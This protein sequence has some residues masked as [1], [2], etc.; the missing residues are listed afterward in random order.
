[1]LR[2]TDRFGSLLSGNRR[3]VVRT[4]L[5]GIVA[6]IALVLAG[7]DALADPSSP[8]TVTKTASSNPVASGAQLT[9]TIVV[10]NTA[11]GSISNVVFND[12][13]NGLGVIQTPPA[14]PQLILTSTK[15]SCS[16]GGTNGNLVTCAV[17]TMAGGESFTVTIRGQVTAGAGTTLNNTASVTGTKSAQNF[18]TQSNAVAVLVTGGAGGQ[19]DL[20]I[21]K[22]G[23]TS[24]APS[25]AMTY[26]LTVNNIG[27]ANATNVKVVDTLPSGVGLALSNAITTTSLFT[28]LVTGSPL[29]AVTVTCAGGAVNAGQ[30]G[31]ITINATAPGVAGSI[32]NTAVVDPDNTIAETNEL[33]NTSASVNTAVGSSPPPTPLLTIQNTDGSPSIGASWTTG[34]GPDPVNPGQKL[35][36]KIQVINTAGGNNATAND[37]VVTDNTQGLDAASI[38][39]SQT[40]VG[41][42]LAKTDGCVV[43]APQV[44][45]T[46]KAMSSGGTQ[47]ITISGTVQQSAGSSLFSTATVTGNVKNTG[48]SNTASEVTTIRPQV[49]LTITKGGLP[50]PVCAHSWPQA[51]DRSTTPPDGIGFHAPDLLGAPSGAP[52][53][54]VDTPACLG[55]LR[56]DF[57]VGNS[58]NGPATN[59]VVRD[60]LPAGVTL[61]S[62]STDGSFA[63]SVDTL[64][65]IVT[66]SNGSIPAA[67]TRRISFL[68]V[69]PAYLGTI[70]NTATVDPNNAIFEAD[71][72]NNMASQSTTVA[73]GVD[74]VIWKGDQTTIDPPGGAPPLIEGFDPIATNG[75]ETYT[76]IVDNVGTQDSTG[77]KVRD[78]L[79]A[80]TKFLSVTSDHGFTCS[81]DGAATGGNV[82]CISG[83]LLGTES[84]FYV[85][86]AGLGAPGDD[87]ATITIKVFVTPFVQLVGQLMHNEVRVDPD[88][89]IPEVNELNNLATQDTTVGVGDAGM[90]AF[91]QLKI[92]KTQT[93][94]SLVAGDPNSTVATNG[95]LI[96]NL[97]VENAGTDP[98]SN[99][100]VRDNLPEGTRFISAKDTNPTSSA[101]FFCTQ[102]AGVVNCT[103]GDFSGSLNIIPGVLTARDI[104]IKVFAPN[105]PG[106]ITNQATVDP[107]NV[108]AEGNEFDNDSFV[109]TT[110]TVGGNNMFNELTVS[111]VQTVPGPACPPACPGQV[112][113]SSKVTYEVT[114][115][116]LGSDPAFNV[117]LTDV[118][119][120]GFT[121][122]SAV[123]T[124]GPLDPYHFTC[125][126][127]SGNSIDC[128]GATLNGANNLAPGEP[129]L[130]TVVVKA[131][132][133]AIPGDYTNTALVDPQ[134]TIPEGN[135]TNNAANVVTK[136]K[137]GGPGPFIDLNIV[138]T[139]APVLDQDQPGGTGTP[140]RVAPGD[141]IKY[142]LEVKN[143]ATGADAG[144][145][146]NVKVRDVLPANVT[147]FKAEDEGGGPGNF[148]CGQVPAQPNTIDCTGGTILAGGSRK[149]DVFAV[150]PTGLDKIASD[151]ADIKQLLTNTAIVDPDNT[152]PEGD[153]TN[154]VD[155]VKT[156]VQSKV[157]LSL[158]KDG[159]GSASANENTTYT[160]TVTNNKIWGNGQTAFGVKITDPLPVDLIPLNIE[161]TT[162]TG[163][164]AGN[165]ACQLEENPVNLVTCTGDLETTKTVTVTITAFV[166]LQSGT[167]DNEACVDKIHMID[168]TDETDNCQHKISQITTPA[169]DIQIN[170][171][172]DKGTVTAGETLDYTLNVSNVGTGPTDG[173][174]V[175][176]TDTVPPEVTVDQVVPAIGWDCS[177]TLNNNVSCKTSSM[178]AGDSANIVIKTTVGSTLT[179]PFTNT[180]HV[181]GGG[182]TQSNND[183]SSRTTLVGTAS[184][185]DLEVVSVSDS[186][187]PVNHGNTLTYTAIV[188]N[189][190]TSGTGP[191]AIVRVALPTTGV[192]AAS[193]AV[194]ANNS[195]TCAPTVSDPKTFDCTGNFGASGSTTIT[196]TMTVNSSAPPP[197]ELSATVTADP[198]GAI[199]ESNE[200]NNAIT[201]KTTVSGTV[202]GGSPCVDL[203]AI[204][205][206]PPVIQTGGLGIYTATVQNVGTDAVPSST[207]WSIQFMAIGGAL[208]SS[209]APT[210]PG[211]SCAGSGVVICTSTAGSDP[212]DLAPG[213]SLTFIVTVFDP[214]PAGTAV[215][216]QVLADNTNTVSELNEGNNLG[217]A[218]SATTL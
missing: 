213:A 63:C 24:V 103:G 77:I 71:E 98:V 136:V 3:R 210:T 139:Q 180:A 17:G 55:G 51:A 22:T 26:T 59:V 145:A 15:G 85:P 67:S 69:A 126:P 109:D 181:A 82:T 212:M 107:D 19:S 185:V 217:I 133:S 114:V 206:G 62:Y 104:V 143:L 176:V 2:V 11:G 91:N 142:V 92:T 182:D 157:N 166:T 60:P 75:T 101:R 172:A 127:A 20:S 36:Y 6:L 5:A 117:K 200:L 171:T 29:T 150:A 56:Y 61:D 74:L 87:F 38:V 187:D 99:V 21:N 134:N 18:T 34:A 204:A 95:T 1:M 119:P 52:T 54:L 160:I 33:N 163:Q 152:I 146:F 44:K 214:L 102:S 46:V 105:T 118:L 37:V 97:H 132:S 40:V 168:E 125:T 106:E 131:F 68:V 45:C 208:V 155:S 121:F 148:T 191:G 41:G 42:Q 50:N 165:F 209:V 43:A 120:A 23:P 201:E 100:V 4:S 175:V 13:V 58:G 93:D 199:T 137:N 161:A 48:V 65:Q 158:T 90:G 96:Y 122:I 115:A 116:N 84:E 186:P 28:C 78:T 211:V 89:E 188:T 177:A 14:L 216:L 159:P 192:P 31:T 147:F 25:G 174:D 79:P 141:P 53:P 94:P 215:T 80:G 173:S 162:E 83:H 88:N 30:N 12:Q 153:E 135:E 193:M 8:I 170:K 184:A 86:P 179:G 195:F 190:G 194:T 7:G 39:A 73:T 183:N 178:N 196:A 113:T 138:K 81:H 151:Q 198:D 108:V 32:T 203:L 70:T 129:T 205:T 202:C 164:Q 144:D 49:D 207:I 218:V 16:Q 189:N 167:L 149:I 47:T 10:K 123:D 35:T 111:K 57:V 154:N 124:S 76:V 112:A 64:T 66:C 130:R 9:Y 197:T 140:V 128:T 27:T 72:T 110:V 169:P 156:I